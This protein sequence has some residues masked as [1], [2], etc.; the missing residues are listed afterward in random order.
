[1]N[2]K[3]LMIGCVF[4]VGTST[5]MAA[6]ANLIERLMTFTGTSPSTSTYEGGSTRPSTNNLRVTDGNEESS[7]ARGSTPNRSS[8][9]AGTNNND[10]APHETPDCLRSG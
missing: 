4:A 6:D 1:M 9:G 2:A 10:N 3:P 5:A 8:P 7:S